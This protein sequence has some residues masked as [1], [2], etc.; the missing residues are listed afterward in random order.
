MEK[1]DVLVNLIV[2]QNFSV[3]Q[4]AEHL[5]IKYSTAKHIFHYFK[6][7]GDACTP[8]MREKQ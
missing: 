2:H 7:H 8:C 6:V 5:G 1:W 4:A 3:K